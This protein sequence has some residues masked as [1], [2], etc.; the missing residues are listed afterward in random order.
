MKRLG[1]FVSSLLGLELA[2]VLTCLLIVSDSLCIRDHLVAD[3][4]RDQ[5]LVAAFIDGDGSDSR[6]GAISIVND[7]PVMDV[8][9][10]WS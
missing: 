5:N 3:D 6:N 2:K 7:R 8:D 9:I 4:R 10:P 1:I